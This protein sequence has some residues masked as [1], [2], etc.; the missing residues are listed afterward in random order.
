MSR[1]TIPSRI[2]TLLGD[3]ALAD[4]VRLY[5][6]KLDDWIGDD[7]KGLFF[8]PEYTDHGPKHI[9]A[10]LVGAEAL[11]REEAWPL[12]T[13]EDAAVL[14][15]ATVL[16]DSAMHLTA[17]G[18]LD[19]LCTQHAAA[20]VPIFYLDKATWPQL[21][22]EY[23]A[24]ARRWDQRKLSGLLGDFSGDE[25]QEKELIEYIRHPREISN[26]EKWDSRYRKFLGEFIRQRHARLAHE[27]AHA[28]IPGSTRGTLKP[29]EELAPIAD[30]AGFV[31][32]SHNMPLR[33]TFDYLDAKH[34]GRVT[35]CNAH[36]IF[37]MVLIRI[38]DYLELRAD[39]VNAPLLQIQRLRSPISRDEQITHLAIHE[40]R[41]DDRDREA[42]L[43]IA[44]PT[45]TRLFFKTRDLLQ[46]LQH[47][48]D[49]SWAVIGEVFSRQDKLSKLGINLRRIISN[50]DDP[51]VFLE[52]ENPSFYPV[53][54][55]F[56]TA[57]A[58]LLKL[59]VKPLY[60]NAPTIGVRELLQNALDAVL[61]RRSLVAASSGDSP[62]QTSGAEVTI[63]VGAHSDG[64]TFLTIT[65]KGIGMRPETIRDYFLKAGASFRH[66][67]AW[68]QT[69]EKHGR[70]T[71][72]RSGRFGVGAL[73]AFLLGRRLEVRTRHFSEPSRNGIRFSA[74]IEDDLIELH[75]EE[76]EEV[77]TQIQVELSREATE[78]LQNSSSA[79]D[80][81]TLDE[82]R[83]LRLRNREL[84]DQLFHLPSLQ[85]NPMPNDWRELKDKEYA[86]IQWSFSRAPRLTCNGIRV[87]LKAPSALD[88]R[89]EKRFGG[90]PFRLPS[91]S[92]FDPDGKLPLNLQRNEIEDDLFPFA[93]KIIADIARDFCAFLL[94]QAP[95]KEKIETNFF[96]FTLLPH[97]NVP[98]SL[99]QVDYIWTTSK[100]LGF[101]HPW[102]IKEAKIRHALW[103]AADQPTALRNEYFAVD[104]F[105]RMRKTESGLLDVISFL[106]SG[107]RL[108][109]YFDIKP[110]GARILIPESTLHSVGYAFDRPEWDSF[111][112]SIRQVRELKMG[113][114]I[115][116]FGQ[117]TEIKEGV[118]EEVFEREPLS[119]V[120]A[121]WYMD[122]SEVSS[123]NSI[124]TNLLDCIWDSPIV[125]S[126]RSLISNWFPRA[127]SALE[128]NIRL[129][130]E[131]PLRGWRRSMLGPRAPL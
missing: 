52:R 45:T 1:I 5:V 79:W 55:A 15:M 26:P 34:Y 39:R 89:W 46:D 9:N 11:I 30:L 21:F 106:S 7:T 100:G 64:R 97:F 87:D 20:Q 119:G 107:D 58:N 125:P 84:L 75:R 121:E 8:F 40:V 82:P 114:Q 43:I 93:D 63:S 86:A 78:A 117:A 62:Q 123:E 41:P 69:F 16:H 118:L 115:W 22:A 111:M 50:L 38:A 103:L 129:W 49:T 2:N 10:V 23:L 33:G 116:E 112:R 99:E 36:P 60:G 6:K 19:L 113:W 105:F 48:L 18:V 130:R 131:T 61:E 67:D 66:S 85:Q 70:S 74:S 94:T 71:I 44:R 54:T 32:R 25:G 24:D 101:F 102:F 120:F 3:S 77:G 110:I 31:A 124:F 59:L 122:P 80:W 65:D 14:V 126:D 51:F 4:A 91:V 95:S 28:G 29:P 17:D 72:N 83:I 57:G 13:P 96:P 127:V 88:A 53:Q 73:A 128:E 12:L 90:I 27:I 92:V 81:Y 109:R 35:C 76:V 108:P 42:I 37:L 98:P 104:A 56:D 68:R 47:E